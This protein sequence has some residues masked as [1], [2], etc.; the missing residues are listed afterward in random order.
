MHILVVDDEQDVRLLFEQRFRRELRTQQLT[1]HFFTSGQ[2]ALDYI[3]QEQ[4]TPVVLI[5]ADINMPG[6]T[7]LELLQRVKAHDATIKVFMVTAYNDANHQQAAA[8]HGADAYF[9]K[10]VDFRELK[11]RILTVGDA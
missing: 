9:A 3:E 5:L 10:P 7:G 4:D 6:M 11:A 2:A 8:Q 1:F